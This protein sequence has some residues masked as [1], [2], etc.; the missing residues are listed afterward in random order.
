M[1][2]RLIFCLILILVFVP[3]IFAAHFIIGYANDAKDGTNA[4]DHTVVLWN[5]VNGINDNLTDVIGINGNSNVNHAYMIDCELLN[6]GCGVGDILSLKI[7]D[8]GDYY[9]SEIINIT[10]SGAGYDFTQ[11]LSLNSPP[12][13]NLS[14]PLNEA[15]LSLNSVSFNCSANDLD[16]NLQNV[17]LWGNWSGGWH[18]NETKSAAGFNDMVSFDKE[19]PEGIYE[20]GCFVFDNL[21]IYNESVQNYTLNIDK[22][23]PLILDVAINETFVCGTN[24]YVRVNCTTN[25][26]FVGVDNVKI[27]SIINGIHT[28]HSASFLTGDTYFA[29]ILIND[30]GQ[31][32]FNCY[33]I[34]YANNTNNKTSQILQGY[35]QEPDLEILNKDINF[36]NFNPIEGAPVL[37]EAVIQNLGCTDANNIL[38]GF[39]NG[40]PDIL[41]YQIGN[42]KTINVSLLS[43]TTTNITWDAQI[44]NSNIF[45]KT[46]LDD[47]YV[48]TNES[49]NKANQSIVVGAWQV[50]YGNITLEKILSDSVLRNM[51]L[52]ANESTFQGNVF[53]SDMESNVDWT[54]LQAIGKDS[55]GLDSSN[56][57]AEIDTFFSMTNFIDSTYNIFTNFG[58]PKE[59]TNFTIHQNEIFNVPII[60]ST[61]DRSFITG[62]LWDMSDDLTG[63]YDATDKE[64]LIFA[65]KINMSQTGKYGIYDYELNI[66]VRLREYNSTDIS[67]VYFYYDLN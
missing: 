15:N 5:N 14:S 1:N 24:N 49:N 19:I 37:V 12:N 36:S 21:S 30:N 63:E 8:E 54:N 32:M 50:F 51:S 25:D 11:N 47:S 58:V 9:V 29:D 46:D 41:G 27:E 7:L 60:N 62:I 10:V 22:T 55:L 35:T 44:G 18:L 38:T 57:F 4:N 13:V 39:Y 66:P 20:W 61:S 53:V 28:N 48:E 33:S 23:L 2:V 16:G 6:N 34:D 65:A 17:S 67:E 56:D 31:W 64:D 45:V 3:Q 40:D 59:L 42:N 52:W 43:N 26:F